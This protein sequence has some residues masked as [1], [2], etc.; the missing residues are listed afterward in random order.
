METL[1]SGLWSRMILNNTGHRL[2]TYACI[3]ICRHRCTHL[4]STLVEEPVGQ[5]YN[6]GNT[7][8]IEKQLRVVGSYV[9]L[10]V[11]FVKAHNKRDS[12][13]VLSWHLPQ[14]TCLGTHLQRIESLKYNR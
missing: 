11:Q 6:T 8:V 14:H 7:P 2:S 9:H 1:S 13:T 3:N 12:Q 10:F 4:K 5:A